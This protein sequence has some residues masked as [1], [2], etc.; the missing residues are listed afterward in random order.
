MVSEALTQFLTSTHYLV[1]WR[2]THLLMSPLGHPQRGFDILNWPVPWVSLTDRQWPE[3]TVCIPRPWQPFVLLNTHIYCIDWFRTFDKANIGVFVDGE[4]SWSVCFNYTYTRIIS[5]STK[6]F[7]C[8][9]A[10][11][12]P[13]GLSWV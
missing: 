12:F 9:T 8:T 11:N 13:I 3:L 7:H 1:T 2:D 6:V 4:S 5:L 10:L